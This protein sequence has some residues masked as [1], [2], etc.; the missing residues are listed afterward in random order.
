MA[1]PEFAAVIEEV[2]K[3]LKIEYH[4]EDGHSCSVGFHTEYKPVEF[5][6]DILQANLKGLAFENAKGNV[7]FRASA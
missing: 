3:T 1:P 2:V 5:A 6:L 7:H 4:I